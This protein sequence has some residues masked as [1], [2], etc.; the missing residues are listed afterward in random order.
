MRRTW[1]CTCFATFALLVAAAPA[2]AQIGK[3]VLIPAN[4]PEDKALKEIAAAP[5]SAEK[6]AL[7]DKFSA[8]YG[9]GDVEIVAD[10]Q[11]V[12]LYSADKKYDKAF[13]YADKGLAADPDSFSIAYAAFGAA[14][15]K[16]DVDH[17][18]KYGLALAGMVSRYKQK[19]APADEEQRSWDEKKKET[20]AGISD[21]MNFVSGTL[22]NAASGIQDPKR[23]AALLG[24]YAIA[25]ADSPYAEQAQ[26]L[27]AD[28]YRRMREFDKMTSFAQQVLAKDPN[29][30]SML[31]LLADDGS[32]RGVNLPQAEASARK[33]LDLLAAAK[34]PEGVADE[35]W[36]HRVAVQ[37]GIAWSALGQVA[38]YKKNDAG[39]LDS[40]QKAA[41]LLKGENFLY[42]RN[43]YRMG[44]ALL[45]LKRT[46]EAKAALTQ[47]AALDTPY[48][49]LAQ[50]KLNSLAGPKTAKKKAA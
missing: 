47:A 49:Q 32:D 16:G 40:F 7:L 23:Q 9:K 4:S 39:A 37:N 17:E 43:Q 5:T 1:L 45:N 29:D 2:R 41:P 28:S 33:A 12:S 26:T 10:E 25:F 31:L 48:K 8:E 42:A 14:R 36:A 6:L 21:S 3:T 46:P 11:Y 13:E 50:E 19:P 38:A 15:D 18:F 44:F 35:Q 27:V 20:L 22:L 30:I 24:P 34:K